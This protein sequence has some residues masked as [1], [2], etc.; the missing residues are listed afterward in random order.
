MCGDLEPKQDWRVVFFSPASCALDEDNSIWLFF[1]RARAR[2]L[3]RTAVCV[4]CFDFGRCFVRCFLRT[5]LG[6]R[7]RESSNR[8]EVRES[9]AAL[10]DFYSARS[11]YHWQLASV[12]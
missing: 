3:E 5:V 8:R 4:F 2:R 9:R 6:G 11:Y 12:T 1:A 7:E 10:L